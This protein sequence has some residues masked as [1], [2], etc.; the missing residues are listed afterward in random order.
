MRGLRSCVPLPALGKIVF[1]LGP[2]SLSREPDSEPDLSLPLQRPRFRPGCLETLC[3]RGKVSTQ[4]SH[5]PGPCSGRSASGDA[6]PDLSC[7]RA[8]VQAQPSYP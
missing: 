2:Q 6:P 7:S 3:L 5:E 1:S 8:V 4:L